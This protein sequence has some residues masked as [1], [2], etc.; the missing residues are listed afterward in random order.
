[1]QAEKGEVICLRSEFTRFPRDSK[2]GCPLDSPVDLSVQGAPGPPG[3][4]TTP[5]PCSLRS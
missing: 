3:L 1:M 2:L 5:G 4:V